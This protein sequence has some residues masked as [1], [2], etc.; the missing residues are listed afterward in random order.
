M[1]MNY[2]WAPMGP[3]FLLPLPFRRLAIT[4]MVVIVKAATAIT[5][6]IFFM[7]S[8]VMMVGDGFCFGTARTKEVYTFQGIC[9]GPWFNQGIF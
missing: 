8:S 2:A 5:A 4:V 7:K 1:L 3:I 6:N 9:Q